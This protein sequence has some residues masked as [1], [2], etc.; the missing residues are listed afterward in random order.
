MQRVPAAED[1]VVFVPLRGDL[2]QR[3]IYMMW[4]SDRKLS[5]AAECHTRDY[6]LDYRGD[7]D[8]RGQPGPQ[9]PESEKRAGGPSRNG[10]LFSRNFDYIFV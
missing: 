4:A 1:S 9:A 5:D 7:R 10:P 8:G 2:S 3:T 6:F